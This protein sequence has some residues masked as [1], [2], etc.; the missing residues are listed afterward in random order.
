MRKAI[1]IKINKERYSRNGGRYNRT[2]WK[3][4]KNNES[5]I[6]DLYPDHYA[7]KRFVPY[8]Q[9]GIILG[10]LKIIEINKKKFISGYSN[11]ILIKNNR[12]ESN[13]KHI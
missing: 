3:D 12:N 9:E 11:F 8:I 10:N 1:L 2:F 6:F 13:N 7:S 4:I 5:Y